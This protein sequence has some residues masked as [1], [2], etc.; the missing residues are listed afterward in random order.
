MGDMPCRAPQV[1]L[2]L[3]YHVQVLVCHVFVGTIFQVLRP[4]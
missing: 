3:L 1:D 4:F 2:V